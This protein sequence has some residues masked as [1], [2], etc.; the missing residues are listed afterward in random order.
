MHGA[1][2]Y[3]A[4]FPHFDYVNPD[5]P[6]GGS[7]R[8]ARIGTF[9]S[10]NPFIIRGNSAAGRHLV[11]ESLMAR[12][13]DEP[14]TLYGRIAQSIEVPEDR[15]W[16]IFHLN[17]AARFQDGEPVTVDDVIFSLE[18]LRD[19]GRPNHHA[20]YSQVTG[21]ERIDDRTLKLTFQPG[22]DRELPLILGLM[23]V[24]PRHHFQDREFDQVSLD[25]IPGTGPYRVA[26]VDPGRGIVYQRDPNYWGARPSGQ[27]GPVQLRDGALRLLPRRRIDL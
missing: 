14:F 17:P 10:L 9:D 2:K 21:I 26:S 20:Y 25:P 4:A 13:R 7:L 12:S 22:G 1:P 27:S 23:P 8:L 24:L 6:K 11:F 16:V 19:H 3:A 15:S 18:T 5:A